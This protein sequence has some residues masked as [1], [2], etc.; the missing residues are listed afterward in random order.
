MHKPLSV[1]PT[2]PRYF[3]DGTGKAI[4]LTGAHTWNSLQD[5]GETDPPAAFDW[6][7]Y[8]ASSAST[9]TTSCACGGG[10]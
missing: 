3:T 4:L 7:G 1:H 5:M 8:L 10:S 6:N 2:T 9:T